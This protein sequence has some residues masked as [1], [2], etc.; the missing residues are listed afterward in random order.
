MFANVQFHTRVQWQHNQ[1]TGG[2]PLALKRLDMDPALGAGPFVTTS[3][4]IM[5]LVIYL[6]LVTLFLHATA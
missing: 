2:I 3:N 5:S 6:G 4:D 1:L